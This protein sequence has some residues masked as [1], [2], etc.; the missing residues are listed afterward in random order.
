MPRRKA[1]TT[2]E[3]RHTPKKKLV[4]GKDKQPYFGRS[5]QPANN[6]SFIPR[7]AKTYGRYQSPSGLNF[8]VFR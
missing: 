5:T 2:A 6:E 3:L 4:P 8:M 7:A 1:A